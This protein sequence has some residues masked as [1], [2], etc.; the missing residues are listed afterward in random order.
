MIVV[1]DRQGQFHGDADPR[2][3]SAGSGATGVTRP[4]I[5]FAISSLRYDRLFGNSL[6]RKIPWRYRWGTDDVSLM[7]AV[8]ERARGLPPPLICNMNESSRLLEVGE[9]W[10]SPLR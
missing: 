6:R 2:R 10:P 1:N 8:P 9:T 5:Q 4:A 3:Q 7:Q